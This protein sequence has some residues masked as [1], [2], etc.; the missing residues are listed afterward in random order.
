M[1]WSFKN[2]PHF[3][4]PKDNN[5][6][7]EQMSRIVFSTGL[8]W[9][10]VEK[11]WPDIKREFLN[12]SVEK[13]AQ[14]SDFDLKELLNDKKMIRSASK[15]KAIIKNAKTIL[16]LQK[17]FGSVEKYLDTMEKSGVDKLLKDLKKRFSY[18]G[19][20]TSIMFLYGVGHESPA[21]EKIMKIYHNKKAPSYRR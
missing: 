17:E 4:K 1:P 8:N 7:F 13:V 10:V 16:A 20:S 19:N 18:M 14:F 6:Y 21:L 15:I 3:T 9:N 12:F 11:K 2:H 5:G